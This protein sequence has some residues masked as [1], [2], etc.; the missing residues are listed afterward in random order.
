MNQEKCYIFVSSYAV[1]FVT[2][3]VQYK[4]LGKLYFSKNKSQIFN[5]NHN[6]E[7]LEL[8]NK[9]NFEYTLFNS[10]SSEDKEKQIY[11]SGLINLKFNIIKRIDINN[12][13]QII[14]VDFE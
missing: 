6:R 4:T 13:I 11:N 3:V 5:D 14:K 10:L 8:V 7:T 1:T 2:C 12:Y 9:T